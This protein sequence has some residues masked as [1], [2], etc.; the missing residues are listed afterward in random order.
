MTPSVMT[1]EVF[2]QPLPSPRSDGTTPS[3]CALHPARSHSHLTQSRFHGPTSQSLSG[4][5]LTGFIILSGQSHTLFH[6]CSPTVQSML[7]SQSQTQFMMTTPAEQ[8]YCN[9]LVHSLPHYMTMSSTLSPH[10][11]NIISFSLLSAD[12]D[13]SHF[14][15]KVDVISK[16]LA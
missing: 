11:S 13:T 12:E 5:L 1:A 15:E 16:N 9:S 4:L 2:D 10:S 7:T 14:T 6:I 3:L 8:S